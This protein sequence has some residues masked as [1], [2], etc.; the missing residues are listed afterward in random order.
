[1][2]RLDE[3]IRRRWLALL[4]LALGVWTLTPW[5]APLFM[6]WGWTVPGRLIYMLYA[7]FCHQMPQRSWFF[8]GPKLSYSLAEVQAVW[9]EPATV[10]GL[11]GFV[12]TAD[13]GWKLAWSDRMVSF[14]GGLFLFSLFY[15]LLRGPIRRSSWR[16]SWRWLLVLLLPLALDG[17]THMVSDLAGIGVGFRETNAWLAALTGNALPA[18]FYAGDAWSSFNAILRLV[19]G[20]LGSFA[21][22]FWALP[23]LDGIYQ[24]GRETINN[25]V[26]EDRM[27]RSD[28]ENAS[29]HQPDIP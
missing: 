15:V 11:R 3:T 9:P 19:T 22:I 21:L 14:Y 28:N 27:S 26:T 17:M 18:T 20:L 8:F 25:L 12:G 2:A 16:L 6:H 24:P 13:M 29:I 4:I 1:M 10:W 7:A 23:L 5:L